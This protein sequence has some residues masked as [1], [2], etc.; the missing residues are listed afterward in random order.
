MTDDRL[1]Q[2]DETA[3]VLGNP[4]DDSST[5]DCTEIQSERPWTEKRL[6]AQY[7]RYKR[8]FWIAD[9]EPYTVQN[10]PLR[11]CY[12]LTSHRSQT[13]FIDVDRHADDDEVRETLLHEMVHVA[14]HDF[15]AHGLTFWREVDRILAMGA[16]PQLVW[17]VSH[18]LRT[19]LRTKAGGF[20]LVFC[21][22]AVQKLEE[23][24]DAFSGGKR[25]MHWS[26][27]IGTR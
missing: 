10:K 12:G 9:L 14:V 13:I 7:Q 20:P 19:I 27:N 26:K 4:E 22:K 21:K 16:P 23:E 18:Q 3:S 2:T 6:Q 15:P 25:T 8:K 1:Q 24:R 17:P 11:H 5:D